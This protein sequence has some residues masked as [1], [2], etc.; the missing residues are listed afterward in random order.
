MRK[1]DAFLGGYFLIYNRANYLLDT[2]DQNECFFAIKCVFSVTLIFVK[3]L[4]IYNTK[5]L[6]NIVFWQ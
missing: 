1:A 3:Y 2:M 4:H 6:T 5:I